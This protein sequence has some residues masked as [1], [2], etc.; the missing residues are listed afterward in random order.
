MMLSLF[1]GV[2]ALKGHQT[3]MDVIGNNIS[4]INTTGFKSSRVTFSDMLSKTQSSAT[5]P[6]SNVGGTNPKQVGLGASIA[7]VDMVFGDGS[8]QSTGK[9][10]DIALTGAGLFVLKSGDQ[11]YFTR[12]GAFEFDTNGNYVLPGSGMYVQG[13]NGVDGNINTNGATENILVKTG[14]TMPG[15]QSTITTYSGNLNATSPTITNITY[16]TGG[17]TSDESKVVVNKAVDYI[18]VKDATS[19]TYDL[20]TMQDVEIT[21]NATNADGSTD[22]VKFT[23]NTSETGAI[24]ISQFDPASTTSTDTTHIEEINGLSNT[25]VYNSSTRLA[26][27]SIFLSNST[28]DSGYIEVTVGSDVKKFYISN[29]DYRSNRTIVPS[30]NT[31]SFVQPASQ[32]DEGPRVSDTT[33]ILTLENSR[34]ITIYSNQEADINSETSTA[35]LANLL[36]YTFADDADRYFLDSDGNPKSYTIGEA[37]TYLDSDGETVTQNIVSI[38][39]IS[40]SVGSQRVTDPDTGEVTTSYDYGIDSTSTYPSPST[41]ISSDAGAR[42][43]LNYVTTTG[44]ADVEEVSSGSYQPGTEVFQSVNVDGTN[45]I[46]ATLTLSDGTTQKVTTGFYQRTHSIPVTTVVN[47]YDAQGTQHAVS[48]LLERDSTTLDVDMN[49]DAL[50]LAR[51]VDDEG[52]AV[53]FSNLTLS[54]GTDGSYSYSYTDAQGNTQNN[55]PIDHVTFPTRWRVVMAPGLGEQGPVYSS[56]VTEED[57]SVTTAY[58]NVITDSETQQPSGGEASF[59]YFNQD[60]SFSTGAT[61]NPSLYLVYGNGNGSTPTTVSVSFDDVTQYSGGTT[62]NAISDGNAYGILQ[63]VQI[64]GSG[65][66][67]GTYSNGILRSEAQIAVAQFVNSAGLTK[68]GNSLYLQS[69]NSGE[70]NIKTVDDLGLS[71][72]PSALEMS[73]VELATEL[74][75]M[76]VTQRGFQS[77]SKIITVSDEMLETIINMKR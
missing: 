64:D 47:V 37:F 50:A 40:K 16:T 65:V 30:V 48:L 69:N 18:T 33:V 13:W 38:A 60:G 56:T 22:T 62:A 59:I 27:G 53:T 19:L 73:N 71:V 1:A 8:A 67:T 29:I 77:N 14:Q 44:A 57:G 49:D 76:I 12:N 63:S 23:I 36:D 61:S 68:A 42:V 17:A 25:S 52:N 66:I 41:Y 45:V 72:T 54:R 39:V 31:E 11:T 74:A 26:N 34:T 10:T 15:T 43:T 32:V 7:S 70:A 9:N 20:R 21:A 58:L 55:I 4:N 28:K 46:S 5:A 3:R 6:G 75:D 2:S 24:Y 35:D 51:V